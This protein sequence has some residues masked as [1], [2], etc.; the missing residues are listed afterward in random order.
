MTATQ[1]S[2]AQDLDRASAR[3]DLIDQDP[4]TGK[5]CWFLAKLILDAGDDAS[6]IDCGCLNTT[7]ILT[8]R[9]ASRWID[10]YL[11]DIKRAA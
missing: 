11:A 7:A 4:A 10:D 6:A 5:Q 2:I 1:K 9:A 3:A 8:K